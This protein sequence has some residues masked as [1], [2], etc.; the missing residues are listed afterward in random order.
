MSKPKVV[1][2]A[3]TM[4]RPVMEASGYPK[5]DRAGPGL[6]WSKR[7]GPFGL[8]LGL[9]S[10]PWNELTGGRLTVGFEVVELPLWWVSFAE[11][12]APSEQQEWRA[13]A[14][15]V[16]DRALGVGGAGGELDAELIDI[17]RS[18]LEI[19]LEGLAA[20]YLDAFGW[21]WFVEQDLVAWFDLITRYFADVESALLAGARSRLDE[22]GWGRR[23]VVDMP[24]PMVVAAREDIAEQLWLHG[25]EELAV[26]MLD[27]DDAT[28]QRV[29]QVAVDPAQ[30]RGRSSATVDF[31]LT[32]AAVEVL[33]GGSRALARRRRRPSREVAGLWQQ[34]GAAR[35][36]RPARGPLSVP[37]DVLVDLMTRSPAEA[38]SDNGLHQKDASVDEHDR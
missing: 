16:F 31:A 23:D 1:P 36:R 10:G 25:E 13:V 29:M 12:L 9:A 2:M 20:G 15:A 22:G 24:P 30:L 38:D 28:W 19:E 8:S 37:G 5:A 17:R 34:V 26:R 32:H 4:L 33:T 27:T 11:H 21:P 14:G 3:R 35:D 18:M 6:E 7:V